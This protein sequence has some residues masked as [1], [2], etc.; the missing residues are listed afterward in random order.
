M[1]VAV[2]LAVT[3]VACGDGGDSYAGTWR[4][5]GNSTTTWAIAKANDGWWSI[6]NGPEGTPHITYAA[7]VNGQLE[8]TNGR[9][10]FT[11]DGDK[12]HVS[13][14]GGATEFDLVR[15]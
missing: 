5:P 13:L 4:D 9:D 10:T 1:L 7:E 15:Q 11:P 12:L 8:T 2:L 6:D 14:A 3:L